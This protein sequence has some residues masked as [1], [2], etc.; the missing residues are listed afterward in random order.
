MAQLFA[1]L[2]VVP[3]TIARNGLF[4]DCQNFHARRTFLIFVMFD[5]FVFLET[6]CGKIN[7]VGVIV[8]RKLNNHARVST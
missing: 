5:A 1:A 8:M 3:L 7:S 6:G 4:L 2:E